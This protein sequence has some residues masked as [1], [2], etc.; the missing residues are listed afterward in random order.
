MTNDNEENMDDVYAENLKF[1]LNRLSETAARLASAMAGN[2][3]DYDADGNPRC[4]AISVHRYHIDNIAMLNKQME[5][6]KAA[7]YTWNGSQ[8]E[9]LHRNKKDS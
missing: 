4:E 9:R 3:R 1:L 7:L 2:Y 6:V 8:I 5:D